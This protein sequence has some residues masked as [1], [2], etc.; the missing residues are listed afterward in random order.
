MPKVYDHNSPAELGKPVLGIVA[1]EPEAKVRNLRADSTL[2]LLMESVK[3][4]F[5]LASFHR[6]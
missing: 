5:V 6:L 2:K 4:I 1:D 3:T